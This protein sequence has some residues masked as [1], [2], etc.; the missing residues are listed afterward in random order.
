M[1]V[2]I[3][4]ICHLSLSIFVLTSRLFESQ[5]KI[6]RMSWKGRVDVLSMEG[7]SVSGRWGKVGQMEDCESVS[8]L[9]WSVYLV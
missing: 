5:I 6:N 1:E 4:F 8:H 3:L 7:W 9:V 2:T